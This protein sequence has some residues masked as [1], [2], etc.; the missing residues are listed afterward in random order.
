MD[1]HCICYTVALL[2][3]AKARASA[4]GLLAEVPADVESSPALCSS[5]QLCPA[6]PSVPKMSFMGLNYISVEMGIFF[7]N[8]FYAVLFVRQSLV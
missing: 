6:S 8:V 1:T 4:R 2:V 3:E 7:L 5:T